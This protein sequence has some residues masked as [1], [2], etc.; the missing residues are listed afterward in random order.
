VKQRDEALRQRDEAL[1]QRDAV[2]ALNGQLVT[3]LLRLKGRQ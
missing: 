2:T 3:E 1:Q